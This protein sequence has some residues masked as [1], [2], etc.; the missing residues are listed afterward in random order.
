M[1]N[2]DRLSQDEYNCLCGVPGK[3]LCDVLEPK[4]EYDT[5]CKRARQNIGCQR[6]DA[7]SRVGRGIFCGDQRL[8]NVWAA[9]DEGASSFCQSPHDAHTG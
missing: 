4:A 1:D 8:V 7:P 3:G 9:F 6:L 2:S 5:G